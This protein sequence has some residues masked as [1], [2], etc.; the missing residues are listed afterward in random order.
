MPRHRWRPVATAVSVSA[1]FSVLHRPFDQ[2]FGSG[3][4]LG[5]TP[6]TPETSIGCAGSHGRGQVAVVAGAATDVPSSACEW[7]C[8]SS[9]TGTAA[10]A[11]SGES[12]GTAMEAPSAV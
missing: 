12:G 7:G 3:L 10:P 2:V 6:G 8:D 1:Y 4:L 5:V 9:T 11:E